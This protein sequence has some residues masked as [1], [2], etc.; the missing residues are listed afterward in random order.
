MDWPADI[1]TGAASALTLNAPPV[2]AIC[3]TCTS[4]CPEFFNVTACVT[5]PFTT[6]SE[7][8]C[9]VALNESCDAPQQHFP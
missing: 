6:H 8:Q 4:L 3:A 9:L 1:V 5:L 7:I 2:T